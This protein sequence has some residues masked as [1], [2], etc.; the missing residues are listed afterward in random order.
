MGGTTDPDI[1]E[2]V[3]VAGRALEAAGYEVEEIEPPMLFESYLAWAELQLTSM[4][5]TAPLLDLLLGEDAKRF[6]QLGETGYAPPSA[7]SMFLMHQSRWRVASAWR[8]F[9]TEY[10]LVVGPTWTE[11]PYELSFDIKDAE[12]ALKAVEIIRFVLPANVLGLPA[13]CV[14]TGVVNGL[15]TGAQ[16][17]A[18]L[19]R[20]DLCL[21]AAQVV[22]ESIGVLTP[23][24]PR[25]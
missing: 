4:Q 6:I 21:N 15:P 5:M 11:P 25:D 3:R 20:E 24:D 7:E 8:K 18:E 17:I 23:I 22:E 13:V 1:A 2:G 19:L 9:M 12:S 14:P 16:I 10:P